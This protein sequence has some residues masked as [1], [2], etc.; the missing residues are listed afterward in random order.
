MSKKAIR[1]VCYGPIAVSP[2]H[3]SPWEDVWIEC[4]IGKKKR[5]KEGPCII[6][7]YDLNSEISIKEELG[8]KNPCEWR[9][10]YL[11]NLRRVKSEFSQGNRFALLDVEMQTGT[12]D[13]F[14]N[15]EMIDRAAAEEAIA[16]YLNKKG[17]LKSEP[18]FNWKRP[19][20]LVVCPVSLGCVE[21]K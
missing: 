7:T 13:I 10:E 5:L 3:Q 2:E 6:G 19:G 11:K 17:V 9:D 15:Q 18:K 1:M 20:D 16:W 12:P 4:A 8:E 14:V 21:K